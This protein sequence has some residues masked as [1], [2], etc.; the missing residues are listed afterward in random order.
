[1]LTLVKVLQKKGRTSL[2]IK[3]LGKIINYKKYQAYLL[4]FHLRLPEFSQNYNHPYA[5]KTECLSKT[6]L[7]L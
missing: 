4:I 1:M 2:L 7:E 3:K 5:E 6:S